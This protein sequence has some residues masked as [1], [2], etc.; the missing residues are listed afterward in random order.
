MSEKNKPGIQNLFTSRACNIQIWTY[1]KLLSYQKT[2]LVQAQ[3]YLYKFINRDLFYVSIP[4]IL[5]LF[6]H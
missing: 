1:P 3:I 5:H 2:Y 6:R 4:S